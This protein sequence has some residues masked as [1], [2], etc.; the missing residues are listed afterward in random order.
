MQIL[1]D[2]IQELESDLKEIKRE[3]SGMEPFEEETEEEL[4]KY[5]EVYYNILSE[6]AKLICEMIEAYLT[7]MMEETEKWL[8]FL[9]KVKGELEE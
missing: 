8:D 5:G 7:D 3:L 4:K 1:D 6:P 9:N 2:K